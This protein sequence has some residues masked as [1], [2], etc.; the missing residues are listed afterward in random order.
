MYVIFTLAETVFAD[1]AVARLSA[2]EIA[3]EV[4]RLFLH[5]ALNPVPSQQ[6]S[7]SERSDHATSD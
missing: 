6:R 1:R 7:T 5:G 2:E 4:L 3:D